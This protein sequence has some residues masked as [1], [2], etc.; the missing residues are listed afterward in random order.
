MQ[1]ITDLKIFITSIVRPIIK[2]AIKESLK[3][4]SEA[5][6]T[7]FADLPELLNNKQTCQVLNVSLATLNRYA[8][9]GRIKRHRN[10][11]MIR[12]KKTEVLQS[13]KSIVKWQRD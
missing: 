7:P 9:E 6:K 12:F 8:D 5:D 4:Q 13:L 11:K 1:D 10:G 2:E 3:E